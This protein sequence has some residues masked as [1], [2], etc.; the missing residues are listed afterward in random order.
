LFFHLLLPLAGEGGAHLPTAITI[1]ASGNTL[2]GTGQTPPSYTTIEHGS[3]G[4]P[5]SAQCSFLVKDSAA[6]RQK[7]PPTLG[8]IGLKA[9]AA[10]LTS[11][12]KAG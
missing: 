9:L 2:K 10:L 8:L 7:F 6:G 3:L 4:G 12:C 1:R 5:R 11:A